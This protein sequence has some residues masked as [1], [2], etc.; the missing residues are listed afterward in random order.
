MLEENRDMFTPGQGGEKEQNTQPA[1][2]MPQEV[3]SWYT[4]TEKE[5]PEVVSYFVQE[6][7]LPQ[8][9]WA[10][11]APQPNRPPMKKK[12]RG[13]WIFLGCL[14]A[15]LVVVLVGALLAMRDEP[16]DG[17]MPDDGE[18]PSSIVHMGEVDS[19]IPVVA[20]DPSVKLQITQA[21][22]P[23]LSP[24]E[25]YRRVNPSVVT[26]VA[27]ENEGASIGTG[28]VMTANGYILTNA[29]VISDAK[30]AWI[31]MDT[32]VTYEVQLVGFD[33]RQDLAVLKTVEEVDLP[34]ATFGDSSRA[35]VGDTV[36]A[37]GNPLGLE[38]RGTMTD[39]M[40]SAVG[41]TVDME[42]VSMTMLQ[43]TAA[44][45]SGNSGGPLINAYGQV[46]GINTMKMSNTD[47]DH[48]STVE[49]LGFALPISDLTFAVDDLIALGH[50]RG[51][52]VIGVTVVTVEMEE[53]GT[54][55][56]VHS[57]S[58]DS[59]ADEAG[60]QTGDLL[61]AADGQELHTVDDLLVIRRTHQVHD[62]V[63]LTVWRDGEILELDVMLYSDREME[64]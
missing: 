41:R 27:E 45:N 55:V 29:H 28:I 22:G 5:G 12:R 15:L 24:Q 32:G 25:I 34:P 23:E 35:M 53:G 54:G 9:A 13:L 49:G 43:T 7:P 33:E 56:V 57:V 4:P 51:V 19:S 44:L 62:T 61:V 8:N 58:E 14:G 10:P 30:S 20:G 21:R 26:V 64:K 60:L 42:G 46:I 47:L 40:L 37:I 38:L 63:H 2:D 31:A 3:V 18:N 59:G 11:Y 17:G 16:G 36:Y 48:E 6:K 52:P 39:G 1:A 50:Y